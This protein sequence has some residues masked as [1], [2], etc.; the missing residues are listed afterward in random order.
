MRTVEAG[1]VERPAGAVERPVRAVERPAREPVVAVRPEAAVP[2]VVVRDL[3]CP[4]ASVEAVP[5]AGAVVVVP[6]VAELADPADTL[7]AEPGVEVAD[8]V[9]VVEVRLGLRDNPM[10]TVLTR[11]GRGLGGAGADGGT[12]RDAHAGDGK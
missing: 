3:E 2:P 4:V 11:R 9:V 12:G 10:R 6:P 5:H 8:H 7:A 1:V